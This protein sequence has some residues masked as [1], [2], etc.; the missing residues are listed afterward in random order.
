[1][2]NGHP[3]REHPNKLQSCEKEGRALLACSGLQD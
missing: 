2:I 1:L 3:S